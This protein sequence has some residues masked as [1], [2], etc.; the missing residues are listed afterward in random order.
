[1]CSR[2]LAALV[3]LAVA[4]IIT[5]IMQL[6]A[7]WSELRAA[8]S[9]SANDT[10][11]PAAVARNG[12]ENAG[13][14]GPLACLRARI[15]SG[16][17]ITVAALGGSISAGS[18]YSVRHGGSGA[19]L[20]HAKV[21]QALRARFPAADGAAPHD[22]HNGALPATGPAFFEH[23]VAGQLP[24]AA[25][26]AAASAAPSQLV[27]LEFGV[28]TDGEP[29]AFERLL[30]KLLALRPP[31]AVLVAEICEV[32]IGICVASHSLACAWS[33]G[34]PGSLNGPFDLVFVHGL[35]LL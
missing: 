21:A 23:C 14:D 18:S 1:M 30:R 16:Q 22:H 20:Y 13:D 4:R 7:L 28:N 2:S 8:A 6:S 12:V 27:L 24:L 11:L 9:F 10:L 29:D 26:A 15:F 35:R 3:W 32:F 33:L 34:P 25:A 19:Y 17:Q 31:V 5:C